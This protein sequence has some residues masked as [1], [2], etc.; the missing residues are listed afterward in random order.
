MDRYVVLAAEIKA[1]ELRFPAFVDVPGAF[2][3][4]G[5][6]GD[7]VAVIIAWGRHRIIESEQE[8]FY[9][10]RLAV[11]HLP[12]PGGIYRDVR[13]AVAGVIGGDERV[14]PGDAEDLRADAVVG[15]L[16]ND[17]A[18]LARAEDREV[19]FLIA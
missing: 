15:A 10:S 3:E 5:E 13:F 2:A 12:L 11:E 19:G 17:P 1:A 9:V 8:R 7:A 18:V 4:H 14:L 16:L 6:V